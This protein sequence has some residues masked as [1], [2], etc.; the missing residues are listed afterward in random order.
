MKITEINEFK[1]TKSVELTR[2]KWWNTIKQDV[3]DNW[4]AEIEVHCMLSREQCYW[5][6]ISFSTSIPLF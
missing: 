1:D 3:N 6:W 5:K 2:N 4:T